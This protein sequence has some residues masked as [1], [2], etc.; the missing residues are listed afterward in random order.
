MFHIFKPPIPTPEFLEYREHFLP[1]RAEILLERM[2]KDSRIDENDRQ[3]LRRLC[4][5]LSERFHAEYRTQLESLKRDFVPFDPDCETIAET[6]Y[7][8]EELQTMKKRLYKDIQG[9]LNIGN[10][11]EMKDDQLAECL[12]LQPIGGLSVHVDTDDF[13]EFHV[14]YRGIREQNET[15]TFLFWKRL[16]PVKL[17]KRVFVMASF[18]QKSDGGHLLIKMFKDV[19]VENI[20]IIAPK[21]KLGMPIFDRVKI[22][23][24]VIGSLIA[25]ISKL[26]FAFTSWLYF[27]IVLS[28]LMIAAVKGI[29]SFLNSK[30]KYMHRFSSNLY[31][32]NLSNNAAALTTLLDAAEEQEVKE[33]L[34][35]YF[36]LY[37]SPN[38]KLTFEEL[39][40]ESEKWLEEQFG[41]RC[42]FEVTD[43]VRKLFENKF[44]EI[45]GDMIVLKE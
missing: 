30:T 33:T 31:Y 6:E 17:L 44:A 12:K 43:D 19:P 20:K 25:P 5:N 10:Y 34:L 29:L 42:D 41:H 16:R 32:S 26:M 40:N 2:L 39:N 23:G 22:G 35:G 27:L 21:V 4:Q 28:G 24:S 1:F 8:A 13:E 18:K 36:I 38:R 14:Y 37:V 45:S 9:V 3:M 7:S 15:E 11:R